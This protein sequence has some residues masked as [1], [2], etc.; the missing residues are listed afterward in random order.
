M[1]LFLA[2]SMVVTG[3]DRLISLDLLPELSPAL[4]NTSF[5]LDDARPFGSFVSTLTGYR[6]KPDLT[7]LTAFAA[8][9]LLAALLMRSPRRSA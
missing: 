6:A 8:F 3:V 1:L 4:W 2:A 5:L 9:W 7:Q